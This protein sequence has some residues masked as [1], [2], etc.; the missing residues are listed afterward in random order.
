[1][2]SPEQYAS[3]DRAARASLVAAW[4]AVR[5]EPHSIADSAL[6]NTAA[7]ILEVALAANADLTSAAVNQL[8]SVRGLS[9]RLVQPH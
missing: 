3:L 6:L 2:H 9:W 8:W 5:G 1:M 7:L 4:E